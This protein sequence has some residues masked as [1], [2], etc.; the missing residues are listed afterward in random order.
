MT[1]PAKTEA[2]W[3]G[4]PHSDGMM[5]HE[6]EGQFV[7]YDDYEEI[8]IERDRLRNAYQALREERDGLLAVLRDASIILADMP[9][10]DLVRETSKLVAAA[11]KAAP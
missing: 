5:H 9:T 7:E 6:A 3:R 11:L 10:S 8:R 1:D 4:D 2:L